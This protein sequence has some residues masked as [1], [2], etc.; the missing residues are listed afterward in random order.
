M[1]RF[2]RAIG[3]EFNTRLSGKDAG[4]NEFVGFNSRGKAVLGD[5]SGTLKV[6]LPNISQKSTWLNSQRS[7][8]RTQEDTMNQASKAGRE[9]RPPGPILVDT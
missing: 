8:E 5:R 9:V 3:G 1:P 4:A 7:K 6:E 2:L